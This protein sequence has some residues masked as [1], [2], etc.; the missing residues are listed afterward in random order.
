MPRTSAAELSMANIGVNG[1]PAKLKPPKSLSPPERELFAAL[2]AVNTVDHFR[3]SDEPLLCRYV[4]NSILAETAARELRKGAV[5]NG[6]T[7]PWLVVSEKACRALVALSMRL[8]LSPQSRFDGRA[9]A[10]AREYVGPKPWEV[11]RP[12]EEQEA[13]E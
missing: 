9:A 13:A 4:E 7:N 5:V 8:R 3:P 10:R 6:K 1:E 12:G 2:V 11:E